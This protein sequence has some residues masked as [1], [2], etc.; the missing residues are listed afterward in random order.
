MIFKPVLWTTSLIVVM[1]FHPWLAS[2]DMHQANGQ[3]NKEGHPVGTAEPCWRSLADKR[4]AM[5]CRASQAAS[6]FAKLNCHRLDASGFESSSLRRGD[7][8]IIRISTQRQKSGPARCSNSSE[9]LS[10]MLKDRIDVHAP[11]DISSKCQYDYTSIKRQE[12]CN[13]FDVIFHPLI[14]GGPSASLW[15]LNLWRWWNCSSAGALSWSDHKKAR[16]RCRA[17]GV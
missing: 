4:L 12:R 10:Q 8:L 13:Q 7:A 9:L 3:N 5:A 15:P 11:F 6:E 16:C 1:P 2:Q 17:C 14:I